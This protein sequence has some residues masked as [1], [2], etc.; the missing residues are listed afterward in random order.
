[1]ELGGD[2]AKQPGSDGEKAAWEHNKLAGTP[3][4]GARQAVFKTGALAVLPTLQV[5]TS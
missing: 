2:T 1:M 4:R 5:I 3:I